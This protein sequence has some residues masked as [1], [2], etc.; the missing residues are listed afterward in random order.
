M[1]EKTLLAGWADMDFNAHMR[2]TA[3]L[4]KSS[5]VRMMF[6]SENGFPVAEFARRK[7]GPVVMKDELEYFREVGLLDELRVTLALSGLSSDA[8]R[9]RLRN[10]LFLPDGALAARVNSTGGWLDLS[11]RRLSVPPLPLAK[12]MGRLVRTEDFVP[13]PSSAAG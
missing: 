8:S 11:L 7:I 5:D 4:D 2:N 13:L 3:Y 10:E 6:F 9:F 1:F 12:A